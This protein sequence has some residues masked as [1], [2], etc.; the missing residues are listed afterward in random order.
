[1]EEICKRAKIRS[2]ADFGGGRV[3]IKKRNLQ[4]R[5]RRVQVV[6][7]PS[8]MRLWLQRVSWK[9]MEQLIK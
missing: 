8:E 4:M 2:V 1:M 9:W 6:E 7:T 5:P 3:A